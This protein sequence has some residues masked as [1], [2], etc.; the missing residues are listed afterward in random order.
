[1]SIHTRFC[2]F[3]VFLTLL[4]FSCSKPA[5]IG[6]DFLED[7]KALLQFKDDFGLTL[8]TEKTDS[9]IVHSDNVTKQLV[10]YLC[11]DVHDP[12]FGQYTA[13]I[14]AQPLLPGI[15]T[16]L[17]G[18]TFDSVVLQLRYDTLGIYGTITDP[19]TI[20]V[21]RMD[22]NPAFNEDY[23]S[24]QPF[25]SNPDLLGS[26]TFVPRPTDSVT[27]NRPDD[28]ITLA[29]HVRIP[30]DVTKMSDLLLQDTIVFSNQDSFLNYFKGLRIHMTTGGNTMLGFNLL[31]SV[32]GLS[33]YYDKGSSEDLEYKFVITSG[34]VKTVH[35]E[36]DYSGSPVA[37]AL[38]P[39]PENDY[40]YV[41]G[42]SGVASYMKVE[43]LDQIGDAII[44]QAVMEI[45]C[46]FPEGDNED[47]YPPCR[48]IITQE[49]QDTVLV[50]SEDV[51]TALSITGSSSTTES[52]NQIFGGKVGDRIAGPPVVYKYTMN[53]TNQIKDI[54]AG[55]QENIIYF[56]PFGKGN[57]PN[58]AVIFGS[59]HPTYAPRLKIS[60]TVI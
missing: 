37:A 19:V 6:S 58:R 59:N 7:E 30:L 25:A 26:L 41:Q 13:E 35:M 57:T 4:T 52:F 20:E 16:S 55:N 2:I 29:A 56:N 42:M 48:Y 38:G 12:V 5:L 36:H 17:I 8:Y 14:F 18:S 9:V 47:F 45:Y 39:E 15:A 33:Y 50:N 32:T 21:Y 46:T 3:F 23:Y 34:S 27:L 60:Y 44:N 40:S 54:H 31:N 10:T 43:G 24:N 22:E 53:V 49:K 11:G 51:A 28:T 1:M